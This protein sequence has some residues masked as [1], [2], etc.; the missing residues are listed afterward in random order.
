MISGRRETELAWRADEARYRTE[1]ERRRC[2][3]EQ[4]LS[5]AARIHT[6]YL[7]VHG[8]VSSRLLFLHELEHI[9]IHEQLFP[10]GSMQR[11]AAVLVSCCFSLRSVAAASVGFF[12][13]APS[14]SEWVKSWLGFY[15]EDE[16]LAM[17]E[18]I[19]MYEEAEGFREFGSSTSGTRARGD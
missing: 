11:L 9:D 7:R 17:R 13:V 16:E 4:S 18:R 12:G 8:C 6:V 3:T 14:G 2:E 15:D 5:R 1:R 10:Q 19:D